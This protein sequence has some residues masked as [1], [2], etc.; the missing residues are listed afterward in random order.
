MYCHKYSVCF[1][2]SDRHTKGRQIFSRCHKNYLDKNYWIQT[3][4]VRNVCYR[5]QYNNIFNITW[6]YSE[7]K[8]II[9][10]DSI[11]NETEN[12][13]E[14]L[15]FPVS[16]FNDTFLSKMYEQIYLHY[17][18]NDSIQL[19]IEFFS[20]HLNTQ[21]LRNKMCHASHICF[22]GDVVLL[23]IH[24]ILEDDQVSRKDKAPKTWFCQ[25]HTR[26]WLINVSHV[27]LSCAYWEY[28]VE[29]IYKKN[30]H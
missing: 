13:I 17:F 10:W 8:I 25:W 23:T 7:P 15:F 19:F 9:W 5:Y 28:R 21:I 1:S 26:I 3:V 16:N 22:I 24:D 4:I 6:K 30:W 14:N 29:E 2:I 20:S 27:L 12:M 18:F 11:K